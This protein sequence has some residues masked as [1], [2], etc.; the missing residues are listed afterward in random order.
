MFPMGFEVRTS[1]SFKRVFYVLSSPKE[2][3]EGISKSEREL[4]EGT[5]SP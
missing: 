3:D 5:R 1:V 4:G 2:A